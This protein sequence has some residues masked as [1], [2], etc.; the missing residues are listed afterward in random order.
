MLLKAKNE[1]LTKSI[2][3]MQSREEVSIE[4]AIL[5]SCPLY[6]QWAPAQQRDGILVIL[7]Q[8]VMYFFS[9][10]LNA[11]AEEQATEDAIFYLGE[12]LRKQSI[13]LDVYLRVSDMCSWY[14]LHEVCKITEC[15]VFQQAESCFQ[16]VRSLS[17]EQFMLRATVQKCREKAGLPALWRPSI[18]NDQEHTKNM[19]FAILSVFQYL[20]LHAGLDFLSKDVTG[21]YFV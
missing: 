4:D 8:H 5:P 15:H 11:F 13:D 3:S 21:V 7:N 18:L 6:K 17:T 10:I 1:E 9:R 14:T 2:D 20:L 19:R 16:Q 12:A